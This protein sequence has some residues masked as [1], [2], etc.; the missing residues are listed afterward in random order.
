M[1]QS[2]PVGHGRCFRGQEMALDFLGGQRRAEQ[3][4][5]HFRAALRCDPVPL[6]LALHP[7]R[8]RRHAH[9]A[10]QCRHRPHDA[11][12]GRIVFH[13]ADERPVDLDLVEGEALQIGQ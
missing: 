10:R 7:L 5:L 11:E 13:A 1:P 2:E 9:P 6:L 8:R 4:A 12:G 3:I